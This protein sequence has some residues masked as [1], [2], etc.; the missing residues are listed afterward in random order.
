MTDTYSPPAIEDADWVD[1]LVI[2]NDRA[3]DFIGEFAQE[4]AGSDDPRALS[5][6]FAIA[7]RALTLIRSALV[8]L[9]N[10]E[11][12][13]FRIMARGIIECAMHMESACT[14]AEYLPILYDDDQASRI[15]RGK[16][17]QKTTELS[18]EA[19]R[20][21]QQFV[22]GNGE[23]KRKS[24]N[25]G[26]LSKGSNFPRFQ[27]FYRQISADAEHVTWTSLCRHPQE[28]YDRVCLELDPQ[29][30]DEEMF[31]TIGLIALAGM[32]VVLH[33]RH[34]LGITQNEAEFSALGRRYIE[35][36]RE[37]V[38]EFRDRHRDEDAM[39]QEAPSPSA[40]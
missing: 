11:Q 37:G 7:A 2:F 15:S 14:T 1:W 13:A 22:M 30:E 31:D 24:L 3:R 17:L 10:E 23:T 26:E 18:E 19:N 8:L 6:K 5:A 20:E 32:T 21:L 27:L 38:A 12:L 35:L 28:K 4:T 33:L 16:L 40:H 9:Q 36:Y 34:S 29:L 25:I 39:P